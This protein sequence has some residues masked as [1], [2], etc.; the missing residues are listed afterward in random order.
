MR[1][2]N[3]RRRYAALVPL[4][5]VAAPFAPACSSSGG[6]GGGNVVIRD[7]NNYTSTSTLTIPTIVTA[8]MTDLTFTWDGIMKDLLCHPAGSIDN[9]AFLKITNMMPDAVEKKLAVGQLN[10]NQVSV[11]AEFKTAA[12]GDGGAR[13]TSAM[14]SKFNYYDT[15]NPL[16]DYLASATTQYMMLFTTGTTL[17]VGAQSMVFIQP[18]ASSTNTMVAA[19]DA[20]SSKV[21]DFVPTLSTMAVDVPIAGPWKLDWSQITKDNFGNPIDFSVTKLDKVEV[22]FFQ[23]KQ[24]A[25]IQADF[26]NTE[27][28]ATSLYTFS[29]PAGQKYVDLMTAETG[30]GTFPG[31]GETDGT[32]A[33]AILCSTCSVPAPIV[34]TILQPQ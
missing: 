4:A 3:P 6:A 20:C 22:G 26:L 15:F 1:S 11:Y 2:T 23:N 28:D 24:P 34:F 16:T 17:G 5:L 10:A 19:P 12:A 30:G 18:S 31:F 14:L 9:V 32:W 27:Q 33:A 8:Q 25:D 13:A 7:A 21:L 29:V